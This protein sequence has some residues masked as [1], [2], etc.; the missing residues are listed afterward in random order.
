M[1]RR[2]NEIR[3]ERYRQDDER[4]RERD[5]R[6]LAKTNPYIPTVKPPG[7]FKRMTSFFNKKETPKLKTK[8][9][10]EKPA[11]KD[12]IEKFYMDTVDD[13][14][15]RQYDSSIE[16]DI[17]ADAFEL[18]DIA[19]QAGDD[20]FAL[21]NIDKAIEYYRK[22]LLEFKDLD[23]DKCPEEHCEDI[24]SFIA[25]LHTRIG[26]A[27]VLENNYKEAVDSFKKANEY[28]ADEKISA[29]I[30]QY[31]SMIGGR[32]RTVKKHKKTIKRNRTKHGKRRA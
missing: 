18:A 22:G 29:F 24:K 14:K 23:G 27:H 6:I 3:D 17:Y 15:F 28:V 8:P 1:S 26:H 2:F 32:R 19:L 11:E 4:E 20:Y 21:K 10:F 9:T 25:M 31:S 16:A 5:A 7:L 13:Y 12:L 30:N